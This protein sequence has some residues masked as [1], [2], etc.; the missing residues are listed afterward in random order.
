M[1]LSLFGDTSPGKKDEKDEDERE[2][3]GRFHAGDRSL[4]AAIYEEHYEVVDRAVGRVLSATADRE[5]VVHEVFYRLLASDKMRRG[6]Q[7]GSLAG[8]LTTVAR[9][10][11]IDFARR[12]HRELR[13]TEAYEQPDQSG[14][15]RPGERAEAELLVQRFVREVLPAEWA[16]VFQA[17]FL[18]GLSQREAA[19]ALGLHRT[20]LAYREFRIDRMLKKFLLGEDAT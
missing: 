9:N 10:Q 12:Y 14:R 8:W 7:G 13:L 4:V 18:D 17:R 19:A 16:P 5:S 11:A 2:R 3:L 20:T 1:L 15:S 6:F